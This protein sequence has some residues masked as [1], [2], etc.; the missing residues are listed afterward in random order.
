MTRRIVLTD[1]KVAA[2]RPAP[3][4]N[5]TNA[6]KAERDCSVSSWVMRRPPVVFLAV[7]PSRLSATHTVR[8]D[9]GH[10]VPHALRVCGGGLGLV[11]HGFASRRP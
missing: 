10:H 3:P 11:G 5:A 2:V 4:A 6:A 1:H 8:D 7:S 9:L